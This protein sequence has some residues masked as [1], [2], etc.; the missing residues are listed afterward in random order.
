MFGVGSPI[1]SGSIRSDGWPYHPG[2][3]KGSFTK[4]CP[5][6]F[7]TVRIVLYTRLSGTWTYI[8]HHPSHSYTWESTAIASLHCNFLFLRYKKDQ[9]VAFLATC[10]LHNLLYASLLSESGPP[11]LDFEVMWS[12]FFVFPGYI[13]DRCWSYPLKLC[14]LD[15]CGKSKTFDC[16]SIYRRFHRTGRM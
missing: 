5:Y 9:D 3:I 6:N 15:Q 11:L 16:R 4:T 14:Q 7:G 1:F 10:S 2:T 13:Y 8:H 12:S